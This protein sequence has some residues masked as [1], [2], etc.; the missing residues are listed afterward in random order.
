MPNIHENVAIAGAHGAPTPQ[1]DAAV[2]A[3]QS[4]QLPINPVSPVLR[5]IIFG[6]YDGQ[7][8]NNVTGDEYTPSPDSCHYSPGVEGEII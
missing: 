6:G 1:S 2:E 8:P 5:G 4:V 7:N 3:E